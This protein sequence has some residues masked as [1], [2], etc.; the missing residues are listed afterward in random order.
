MEGFA[1]S[2]ENSEVLAKYLE[3]LQQNAF[4]F[5]YHFA[6]NSAIDWYGGT[7]C[8]VNKIHK[9]LRHE[10]SNHYEHIEF[11]QP[12]N[13]PPIE[14]KHSHRGTKVITY[15][16][17]D[18][19]HPINCIRDM[20]TLKSYADSDVEDN[21]RGDETKSPIEERT[22]SIR[23][24]E[25]ELKTVKPEAITENSPHLLKHRLPKMPSTSE[26]ACLPRLLQ[27]DSSGDEDELES[28]T[29]LYTPL[30]YLE[31]KGLIGFRS[32]TS[33]SFRAK[34]IQQHD[35]AESVTRLRI[36]YRRCIKDNQ[37]QF[38]LIIYELCSV[39][40]SQANIRRNLTTIF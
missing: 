14:T 24:A 33:A 27:D 11:L 21:H 36:S 8:V 3:L 6:P 34:R 35:Y 12:S 9:F 37:L 39:A 10:V 15:K 32:S 29:S 28:L 13:C 40:S 26:R 5:K 38:A 20:V 4:D 23:V 17:I 7:V 2:N 18:Y 19:M 22:P 31:V 16:P 25:Y 30:R 1:S